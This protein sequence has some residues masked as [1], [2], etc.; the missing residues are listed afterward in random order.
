MLRARA[1]DAIAGLKAAAGKAVS[2]APDTAPRTIFMFPG[3]GAQY[4]GM[5]QSLYATEPQFRDWVERGLN[6]LEPLLGPDFRSALFD[7][8]ALGEDDTHPIRSTLLAQPALFVVEHALAQ[9]LLSRGV[10]PD[11]MIGHSLGEFVAATIAGVMPFDDALRLIAARGQAMRAQPGGAM[12]AVRLPAA[13]L[14]PLLTTGVEI[15]AINA[16]EL[17]TVAG[18]YDAISAFE[19]LLTDREIT[20]RRLHTSHAFHSAAMEPVVDALRAALSGVPLKAPSIAI[21]SSVTGKALT[22]AEATSIDYWA[23]HARVPVRFADAF[24]AA[25]SGAPAV[26]IEVGPG[27]TLATFAQQSRSAVRPAAIVPTLP[28]FAD[29]AREAIVFTDAIGQLWRHGVSVTRTVAP[30]ARRVSLPATPFERKRYWIDR[31]AAAAADALPAL[32]TATAPSVA[33]SPVVTAVSLETDVQ[34]LDQKF[35]TMNDHKTTLTRDVVAMLEDISG[36]TI[37]ATATAASFLELGFDSLLLG[38]VAQRLQKM[39]GVKLTFRQL[40]GAYPSIDALVD[41]LVT[42]VPAPAAAPAV[43]AATA[44]VAAPNAAA[45]A[46]VQVTAAVLQPRATVGGSGVEA[47]MRDQLAAMQ[48][49]IT[50]QLQTLSHGGA[51]SL[52]PVNMPASPVAAEHI[53]AAA[54]VATETPKPSAAAPTSGDEAE[55]EGR[56]KIYRAGAASTGSS[57]TPQ[58]N[59]LIADIVRRMDAKLPTSK[60]RAQSSRRVLADPRSV[61]GFRQEWKEIVYPIIAERSKGSKLH[62]ADGNTFVDLVN[63]YG[64]TAFGHA[65]DFVTAAVTEQMAKGF[66]IGPQTP[67]AADVAEMFCAMTGNERATFCNTGSEAVMAAMRL[68]RAVTGRNKVVFFGGAYHGQFDEVLAKGLGKRAKGPGAA[69]VAPG[70]PREAVSNMVVLSYD[71]PESLAWVKAQR[72]RHRGGSGRDGAKPASGTGSD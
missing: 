34:F 16:P 61:S 54:A 46:S 52:V 62:D 63:G 24:S 40:L 32:Q 44:T 45:P 57:L 41:H 67:L 19:N 43:V 11:V 9:L 33:V 60:A 6:V 26:C 64:Q 18:S 4:P 72:R 69:P 65:P 37:E 47:L 59:A 30:G 39:Y 7:T 29:R 42:V 38:Q 1:I 15:A 51:A 66:A 36:E 20:H 49:I 27:R 55:G 8:A 14:V 3:Q 31:R 23:R 2:K 12:L 35:M 68:A 56:F 53:P 22:A 5:G 21:V 13:E 17:V 25:I 71:S 58:Q 50:Q 70:I 10:T 48:S 28:D